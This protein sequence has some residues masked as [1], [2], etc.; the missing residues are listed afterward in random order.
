MILGCHIGYPS[1]A[2]LLRNGANEII[3]RSHSCSVGVLSTDPTDGIVDP[4]AWDP[5]M[6]VELGAAKSQMGEAERS[7]AWWDHSRRDPTDDSFAD[8]RDVNPSARG[9]WMRRLEVSPAVW[10][11]VEESAAAR[12][13]CCCCCW[14]DHRWGARWVTNKVGDPGGDCR[15]GKSVKK[16]KNGI[17]DACSTTDCCPLLSILAHSCPLFCHSCPLLLIVAHCCPLLPIVA[18]CKERNTL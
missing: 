1:L 17:R 9:A 7:A 16:E 11:S 2:K 3:W 15:D 18:H 13:L 4:S 6:R 14:W 10:T 5:W 12:R 8:I